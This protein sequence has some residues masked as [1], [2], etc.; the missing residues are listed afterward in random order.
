MDSRETNYNK[1]YID[2]EAHSGREDYIKLIVF[3][4][5]EPPYR[6]LHNGS[7]QRWPRDQGHWPNYKGENG[8]YS[9]FIEIMNGIV[10]YKDYD[11]LRKE[12]ILKISRQYRPGIGRMAQ[13]V[14]TAIILKFSDECFLSSLR[15]PYIINNDR[16]DLIIGNEIRIAHSNRNL[17]RASALKNFP[18]FIAIPYCVSIRT[19]PLSLSNAFGHFTTLIVDLDHKDN[20]GNYKPFVYVYDSAH[21][22]CKS[23]G[24]F[25]YNL[26]RDAYFK[27]GDGILVDNKPL[28]E[29]INYCPHCFGIND[30]KTSKIQ[31]VWKLSRPLDC[32]CGYYCEASINLLLKNIDFL[33]YGC[34][35]PSGQQTRDFLRN[36]LKNGQVLN[37]I[38]HNIIPPAPFE[39]FSRY[40]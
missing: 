8:K 31:Y 27:F 11:E 2:Y 33:D 36:I 14:Y 17:V 16:I 21:F 28:N 3:D 23:Y 26:N 5:G 1:V 38:K 22:L 7:L 29:D 34:E 19:K 37:E 4:V 15:F 39:W 10:T 13:A 32:R 18:R 40:I 6:I 20:N 12:E 9:A 25:S 30:N 35:I 24:V